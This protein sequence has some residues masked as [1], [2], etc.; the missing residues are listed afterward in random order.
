[1]SIEQLTE[2][3]PVDTQLTSQVVWSGA[4]AKIVM[5]EI[6]RKGTLL[7]AQL[8]SNDFMRKRQIYLLFT[9]EFYLVE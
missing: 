4:S 7:G 6:Q 5:K 9:H 1:M 3:N 2:D 8:I